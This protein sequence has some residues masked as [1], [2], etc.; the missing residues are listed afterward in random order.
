MS[1][2]KSKKRKKALWISIFIGIVLI[3]FILIVSAV[4]NIGLKLRA[5][6]E[7]VEYSFY[8]LSGILVFFLIIRPLYIILLSPSFSVETTLDNHRRINHG[9]YKKVAKRLIESKKLSNESIE[10]LYFSMKDCEELRLSLESCYE[11]DIRP[12]MNEVIKKH[13]ET[14]FISTAVSQ[15]GKLDFLSV[16]FI[17]MRLIKELVVLAGFRPNFKKM[18]KLTFN[19]LSTALIAEGLENLD[20]NQLIPSGTTKVISELPFVKPILSSF[21]QG[22]S[23]CLLTLRVGFVCQNYLF[24]D[25]KIM[26]KNKVRK[27]ALIEAIKYL[28]E[29]TANVMIHFPKKIFTWVKPKRE[30]E[31]SVEKESIKQTEVNY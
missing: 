12:N 13:A 2:E 3:I 26:T 5:L 10:N 9:V 19:V 30:K 18:A 28:P 15:N 25:A 17:N 6:H 16:L 1:E 14:V 27:M 11:N 31:D 4:L 23:N 22:I 24:S 29:C 8:G 7:Y 21:T 20:L